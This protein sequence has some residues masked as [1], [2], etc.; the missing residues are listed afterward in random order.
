MVYSKNIFFVKLWLNTLSCPPGFMGDN[1]EKTCPTNTYGFRCEQK[2]TCVN[3]GLC[4]TVDG[5]CTCVGH[6]VGQYC[7]K[8]RLH[9]TN[10]NVNF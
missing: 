1:C 2:C 7:E 10:N 5:T 3:S 9:Q 6:W 8:R 4:N